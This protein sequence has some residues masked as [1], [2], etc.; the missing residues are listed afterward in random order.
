MA[1]F[2]FDLGWFDNYENY[3][4]GGKLKL[5]MVLHLNYG[6]FDTHVFNYRYFTSN[7]VEIL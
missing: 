3:V 5:F 2:T 6:E 7:L 4:T 1:M